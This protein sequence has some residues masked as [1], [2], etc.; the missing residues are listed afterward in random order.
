M[1]TLSILS[2]NAHNKGDI[3]A[4]A[5]YDAELKSGQIVTYQDEDG[6]KFQGKVSFSKKW[7]AE[8]YQGVE[9][10]HILKD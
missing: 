3:V 5:K 7:N 10:V 2:L 8:K 6:N 1:N 4:T 9:I